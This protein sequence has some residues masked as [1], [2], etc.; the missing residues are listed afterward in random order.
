MAPFLVGWWVRVLG[1]MVAGWQG[2]QYY[3]STSRVSAVEG[4]RQ[5]QPLAT[6]PPTGCPA[7]VRSRFAD[8]IASTAPALTTAFNACAPIAASD[9]PRVIAVLV[10]RL[11]TYNF[12]LSFL[13]VRTHIQNT[14]NVHVCDDDRSYTSA[15]PHAVQCALHPLVGTSMPPCRLPPCSLRA[16]G[17]CPG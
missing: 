9:A 1:C 10:A 3:S 17:G 2:G 8:L 12:F 15:P 11:T 16:C 7:A 6:P 4:S 14:N 5:G 13:S